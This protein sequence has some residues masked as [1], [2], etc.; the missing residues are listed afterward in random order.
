MYCTIWF[1]DHYPISSLNLA[2]VQPTF[3]N[4]FVYAY[5]ILMNTYDLWKYTLTYTCIYMTYIRMHIHFLFHAFCFWSCVC[6][7][8]PQ[9]CHWFAVSIVADHQT[10]GSPFDDAN[11]ARYMSLMSDV[12]HEIKA[13]KASAHGSTPRKTNMTMEKQTIWRCIS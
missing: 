8:L 12:F 7:E 5:I 10:L 6:F 9:S 2:N 3:S 4:A 1:V 13:P 11:A